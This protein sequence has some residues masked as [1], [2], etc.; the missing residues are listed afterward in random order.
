MKN[1]ILI[2]MM[3]C[4]KTTAGHMLAQQLGRPF[5][6]CDELMEGTTGRTIS[7]IFAQ[8]GEEHFRDLESQVALELSQREYD[9]IRYLVSQPG[10]VFSREAL[11]EHVWNLSLIH[12]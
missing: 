4:G 6:D 8:D 7:Q 10:K 11:M 1:I 3:G 5:V 2:G 12:I 9:L